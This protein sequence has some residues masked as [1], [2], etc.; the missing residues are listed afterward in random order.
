MT[1][2]KSRSEIRQIKEYLKD[3]RKPDDPL[4][5]LV[6]DENREAMEAQARGST[7]LFIGAVCA[8][9]ETLKKVYA[10][11]RID[12]AIV[13]RIYRAYPRKKGRAA[14]LKAITK[15]IAD[16]DLAFSQGDISSRCS[17]MLKRVEQY[18]ASRAGQDQEFTPFP[19]TWFNQQRYLDDDLAAPQPKDSGWT[20]Q[21]KTS[22]A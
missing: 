8:L 2:S 6:I 4:I 20:T 17:W 22:A 16:N 9:V 14:A 10:P 1:E 18:A 12:P 19:A 7:T 11:P 13:D 3:G 21:R 5:Q 15:A